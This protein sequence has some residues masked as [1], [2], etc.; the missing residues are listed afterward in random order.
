MCEDLL[1]ITVLPKALLSI[2]IQ[3]TLNKILCRLRYFDAMLR[4][5]WEVDLTFLDQ[6]IHPMLV[7]VKEGWHADENLI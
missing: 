7:P 2:L 5:V 3:E 1:D 4:G 6:E